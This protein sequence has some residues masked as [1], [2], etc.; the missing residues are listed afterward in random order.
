MKT[1]VGLALYLLCAA[2]IILSGGHLSN[3]WA[4]GSGENIRHVRV[5]ETDDYFD[6]INLNGI[7]YPP[8]ANTVLVL[9]QPRIDTAT[10]V[11]IPEGGMPGDPGNLPLEIADPI[12][13]TFDSRGNRL[14]FFE[15]ESADLLVTELGRKA[16]DAEAIEHFNVQA[17]GVERPNGIAVDPQTGTLFVLDRVGPKI[18]AMDPGPT[19][20]YGGAV[21]LEEGRISK[22]F[23]IKEKQDVIRGLA[24][25]PANGHLYT[26]SPNR[27]QLYE[28]A[29][30]GQLIGVGQFSETDWI[31]PKGIIFA[32]SL[33]RTD[34]PGRM[35]L[36]IA[37]AGG[38]SGYVSEWLL[39]LPVE[40]GQQQ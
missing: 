6:V 8:H 19:Q 36:Y 31:D 37:S 13:I 9:D 20:N 12:N 4:Q 15:R 18:V 11:L 40:D 21:A 22:R 27:Q 28:I 38:P 2:A 39:T 26:M 25:N 17:L 34:D 14:F 24:F 32:P 7:V 29:E 35:N 16:F 10:I 5:L 30:D 1:E 23:L 33:D 3:T